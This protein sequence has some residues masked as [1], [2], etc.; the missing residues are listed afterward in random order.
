MDI[1]F[2]VKIVVRIFT[3]QKLNIIVQNITFVVINVKNVKW[4]PPIF[5][6]KGSEL[7]LSLNVLLHKQMLTVEDGVGELP[8][9]IAENHHTGSL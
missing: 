3:K 6:E 4:R 1:I 8:Y 9:P 2:N 5:L 7:R